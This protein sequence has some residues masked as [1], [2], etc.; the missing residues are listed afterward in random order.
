MPGMSTHEVNAAT[1]YKSRLQITGLIENP[2][3]GFLLIAGLHFI[4]A[5]FYRQRG[6]LDI[7]FMPWDELWQTLPA[8]LLQTDMLRS[9]WYFHAQPPLFNI[10]GGLLVHLFY[11]HHLA[12]LYLV[13][14]F[15]G[16][17]LAGMIYY[18][19]WRLTHRGGL[20]L[21]IS[22]LL[23]LN[24]S[25]FLYEAYPLYTVLTAFLIVLSVFCLARY[26]ENGRFWPLPA[27]IFVLNLLI[28]TRSIYHIVILLPAIPF[29]LWLARERWRRL[30]PLVLLI[31]LLSVAWYG[32]NLAQFGFW[33]S[34]SWMGLG[35]WNA[36]SVG[37][38]ADEML[39]FMAAG[40]V[41]EATVYEGPFDPPSEFE[42]YGYSQTS[43]IPVLAQDDYN[44]INVLAIAE[45]YEQSALNLIRQDP[46]HFA[47]NII[48]AYMVYTSPPS[49]FYHLEENAL[50]MGPHE[51]FVSRILLGQAL[52]QR[53]LPFQDETMGS[54]LAVL[55]PVNLLVYGLWAFKQ[56]RFSLRNWLYYIR[57]DAVFVF[58]VALIL[59]NTAVS[60]TF[61]YVENVRFQFLVEQLIWVFIIITTFRVVT[62]YRL[63]SPSQA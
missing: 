36:V 55:L 56:N 24:P 59:Y 16:S 21:T 11:P 22:L 10:L 58:I 18:I 34:S 63:Y 54:F 9:L 61:E 44:N 41:S 6:Q 5:L 26:G 57:A 33:G 35:L 15:L 1:K 3:F 13:N 46:G 2:K 49:R 40:S 29:V 38:S 32:K 47:L 31:S 62:Q 42:K 28:L 27:F 48:V 19:L 30:L 20:A 45:M 7:A 39:S 60:I 37:Y 51:S 12:A 4:I 53:Y 14:I 52:L 23:A 43:D 8:H 17:L 50:K 25:L